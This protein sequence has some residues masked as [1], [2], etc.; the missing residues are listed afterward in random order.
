MRTA[1]NAVFGPGAA[2]FNGSSNLRF[3]D[4]DDWDFGTGDYTIDFRMKTTQTGTTYLFD[5]NDGSTYDDFGLQLY[6]G[7][8]RLL[9][10]NGSDN[11]YSVLSST[12]GASVNNGSYHHIALVRYNGVT[13]IYVDGTS[14]LSISTSYNVTFASSLRIGGHETYP[15]QCYLGYMDE[16]RISKGIARWT[17]SFI[18]SAYA[19]N[20]DS[21]DKLLLHF[22]C[23]YTD[24]A[25]G[26]AVMT[27]TNVTLNTCAGPQFN[28]SKHMILWQN[29]T[30]IDYGQFLGADGSSGSA[31]SNGTSGTSGTNGLAGTSGTSG[32]SPAGGSG[33]ESYWSR[34]DPMVTPLNTDDMI[35][36]GGST[37]TE[38]L[39][40]DGRIEMKIQDSLPSSRAGY[41]KIFILTT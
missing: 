10:D 4:S 7:E 8:L 22:D 19:N 14:K 28:A 1:T 39:L 11:G 23:N 16:F 21:Y 27:N 26:K 33:G 40:I 6:N 5:R 37:P 41:T 34:T 25:T 38:K 9:C 2:Y 32:T 30:W 29:S 36:L 20:P 17:S 31:G 13:N 24:S 3:A 15:S 18:P 35:S 12:S